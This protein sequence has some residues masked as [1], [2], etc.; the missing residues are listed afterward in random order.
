[1]FANSFRRGGVVLASLCLIVTMIPQTA[2]ASIVSTAEA[3]AMEQ[4]ADALESVRAGLERQD[5]RERMVALGVDA[6]EVDARLAALTPG[7]LT[8]LAQRFD[9]APAGGD[10]LA[11]IGVVFL[12]LMILEFTGVIDIFKNAP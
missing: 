8:L 11:V 3:V 2:M 12:V 7:E 9:E 6:A 4:H 5:V 10:A 1:M